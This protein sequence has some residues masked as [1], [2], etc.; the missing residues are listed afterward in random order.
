V[1]GD[2]LGGGGLLAGIGTAVKYLK[3]A[4]RIIGVESNQVPSMTEAMAAGHPITVTSGL[5]LADGLAVPQVGDRAFAICRKVMDSLYLVK[6]SQIALAIL[7]LLEWDK[8]VVEGAGASGIAALLQHSELFSALDDLNGKTVVIPIC[9]GN[10]DI[11]ILGRVI[12]QGMAVDR[13][14]LL[15]QCQIS[16]TPNS[17]ARFVNCVG[18]AGADIRDILHDRA[19]SDPKSVL[20]RVIVEVQDKEHGNRVVKGLTE[21]GYEVILQESKHIFPPRQMDNTA[22][23]ETESKL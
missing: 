1:R 3:P 21:E 5:S 6:E 22:H 16:D 11:P 15:L 7:R 18:G 20:L 23:S 9:G 13:R 14:V 2:I 12:S 19:F 10:I 4:V 17:L 8:S